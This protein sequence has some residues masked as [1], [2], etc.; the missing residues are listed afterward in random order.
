MLNT[1]FGL[2]SLHGVGGRDGG[3]VK[4]GGGSRGCEMKSE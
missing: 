3:G 4:S 2:L 1:E